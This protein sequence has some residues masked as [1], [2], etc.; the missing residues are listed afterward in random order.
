MESLFIQIY[1]SKNL[2]LMT[3]FVVQGHICSKLHW[4]VNESISP[5]TGQCISYL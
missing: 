4:L 5:A 2:T 1:K 3:G